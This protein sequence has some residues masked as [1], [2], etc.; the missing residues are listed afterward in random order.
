M[1]DDY[2]FLGDNVNVIRDRQK[3]QQREMEWLEIV[4]AW[5]AT[6]KNRIKRLCRDGI[7]HS[8]RPTVWMHLTGAHALVD[9]QKYQELVTS[10]EQ[11]Q[12]FEVIERDLHR[13]YP[14]HLLFKE[15]DGEGYH[16]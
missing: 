13:C 8:V 4:N 10:T 9:R 3:Y 14:N 2:G 1:V 11:P 5:P 6:S 16:Y 7:P 15:R 12:I